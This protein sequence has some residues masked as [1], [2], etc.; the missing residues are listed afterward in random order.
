MKLLATNYL[1]GNDTQVEIGTENTNF[2]KG[3]MYND[4]LR[5]KT[6]VEQTSIDLDFS[7]E[8]AVDSFCFVGDATKVLIFAGTDTTY[9]DF[10]YVADGLAGDNTTINT[11]YLPTQQTYRYWKI[12]TDADYT[13][14]AYSSY[15]DGNLSPGDSQC[16]PTPE[17]MVSGYTPGSVVQFIGTEWFSPTFTNGTSSSDL[18]IPTWGVTGPGNADGVYFTRYGSLSE[19]TYLCL[20]LEKTTVKWDLGGGAFFNSIWDKEAI[21]YAMTN[22]PT[23]TYIHV[24]QNGSLFAS[25]NT[26]FTINDLIMT[27]MGLTGPKG[28]ATPD[29]DI[30]PAD[31]GF[32]NYVY[33][34]E[35]IDLDCVKPNIVPKRTNT[36]FYNFSQNG[37]VYA[38]AGT[39]Y[40]TLEQ[41]FPV[42][43]LAE[44][45]ELDTY[46]ETTDRVRANI[47][48][49]FPNDTDGIYPPFFGV[50]TE[51]TYLERIDY[52][53]FYPFTLKF[54]EVK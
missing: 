43:T 7:E 39:R 4:V 1:R 11:I 31:L 42:G 20:P 44:Y 21:V 23:D 22:Y 15:S 52:N 16:I 54:R 25:S 3:N 5:E 10:V 8:K 27:N 53:R 30:N 9:S 28:S 35:A 19:F 48:D 6:L 47:I 45:Q 50:I 2:P 46:L 40:K 26:S 51:D 32:V 17:V 13:P 49:Q 34:G 38:T 24:D 33:L 29:I 41:E 14:N 37:E 18:G 36:D 12:T